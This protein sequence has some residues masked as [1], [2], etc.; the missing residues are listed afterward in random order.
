MKHASLL[1]V[2]AL[3]GT[4]SLAAQQFVKKS[5]ALS[6]GQQQSQDAVMML[7][8]SVT[9]A[10]AA[11]AQ[12]SRDFEQASPQSLESRAA[13]IGE[14]CAAGSRTVPVSRQLLRGAELGTPEMNTGRKMMLE[15]FDRTA[16]AL[17]ECEKTFTPLGKPGK[18]EEVR[19]YG[20]H[21]AEPIRKKLGQFDTAVPPF[22]RALQLDVRTLL[23]AGP[24]P[25][26]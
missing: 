23:R 10:Q 12:L 8:D 21:L 2:L 11:L 26:D 16:S 18:G 14:R 5:A 15:T 9:A 19:G 3:A 17:A 24:S 20:N 1:L 4:S 22:A 7:R 13:R 6:P 25:V